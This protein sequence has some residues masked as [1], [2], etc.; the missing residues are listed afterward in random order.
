MESVPL[1]EAHLQVEQPWE[2]S[3]YGV[4]DFF[5]MIVAL[6]MSQK[7]PSVIHQ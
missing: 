4:V 5:C 3:K 1:R 7:L 6:K 2:V